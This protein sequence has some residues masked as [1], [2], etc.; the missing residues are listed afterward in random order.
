MMYATDFRPN[1]QANLSSDRPTERISCSLGVREMSLSWLWLILSNRAVSWC[2]CRF[3]SPDWMGVGGRGMRAPA[4]VLLLCIHSLVFFIGAQAM[5][6]LSLSLSFYLFRVHQ[7]S[8]A[9]TALNLNWSRD[10]KLT[11]HWSRGI[12]SRIRH[13]CLYSTLYRVLKALGVGD[14]AL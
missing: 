7:R 6:G 2:W 1:E 11:W 4:S 9:H 10:I 5:S 8:S 12:E 13:G 3:P 14:D